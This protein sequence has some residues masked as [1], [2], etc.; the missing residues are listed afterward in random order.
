MPFS[1]PEDNTHLERHTQSVEVAISTPQGKVN[2]MLDHLQTTSM[3]QNGAIMQETDSEQFEELNLDSD[4]PNKKRKKEKGGVKDMNVESD[5]D[6]KPVG[7]EKGGISWKKG[8]KLAKLIKKDK[9]KEP[10]SP[11][12]NNIQSTIPLAKKRLYN[13]D[14]ITDLDSLLEQNEN[15]N[16]SNVESSSSKTKTPIA[17]RLRARK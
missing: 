17:R 10:L 5:F 4:K 3:S 16:S 7:K 1:S 2:K 14:V 13:K 6:D 12:D 11:K 9:D 8:K 15:K